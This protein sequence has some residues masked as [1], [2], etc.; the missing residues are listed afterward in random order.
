M[1][2]PRIAFDYRNIL[3]T[4][5][6][7]R[8]MV[9]TI[10]E[11]VLSMRRLQIL[12]CEATRSMGKAAENGMKSSLILGLGT[13]RCGTHSLAELLNR[14]PDA[15]FT[16]ED[17][18]LLDWKPLPGRPGIATRITRIRNSRSARFL[19]DVASFYLPHVEEII[20]ARRGCREPL[21]LS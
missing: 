20:A 16:H 5:V 7:D 18:P 8:I 14:Q 4:G 9:S 19:G 12:N 11:E 3:S 17:F 2:R 13:G 21:S 1:D 6:V 10:P 15:A